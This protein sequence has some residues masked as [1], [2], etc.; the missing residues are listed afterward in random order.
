MISQLSVFLFPHLRFVFLDLASVNVIFTWQFNPQRPAQGI[1]TRKFY[2]QQ[3]AGYRLL[4]RK[5][6][7]KLAQR[8]NKNASLINKEDILKRRIMN[9][10][11]RTLT[12]SETDLLHKGLN[13]CPTP[14]PPRKEEIN[15]GIDA[16]AR[17]LNLKEYHA[18]ED[19]EDIADNP[20]RQHRLTTLEK[21]NQNGHKGPYRPSREPYLNTYVENIRQNIIEELTKKRRFQRNN[22]NERERAALIRLSNDRN[23][24]IKP[25]DKGGATVSLNSEDY[26]AEA[27]RQL[28]NT[29]YYKKVDRDYTKEHEKNIDECITTL[30]IKGDIDKDIGKL[31]RP[32]NSRTPVFYI[33]PKIH[34]TNNPGRAVVSSVNSHT[35]KISAYVDDYLRPLAERL[36]SYIR[37]TTDFI[38]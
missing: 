3:P 14:P 22:L 33:L 25:A 30:V 21:L 26:V 24:V 29:E 19:M 34:K 10:S 37:D 18:P 15:D 20:T 28:D 4:E 16:F 12:K 38:K 17:R 5:R 6:T 1:G 27:L 11:S 13:F 31:L 8:N 9:L 36:P 7:R 35:E 32:V 23:I 2:K